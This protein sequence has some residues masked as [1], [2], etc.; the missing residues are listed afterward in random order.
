MPSSCSKEERGSHSHVEQRGNENDG[1][2]ENNLAIMARSTFDD[3]SVED[4]FRSFIANVNP[5]HTVPQGHSR[6]VHTEL[7][8]SS[9]RLFKCRNTW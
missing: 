7:S 1:Y 8:L 5:S 3:I 6:S 2:S 4:E 9:Q